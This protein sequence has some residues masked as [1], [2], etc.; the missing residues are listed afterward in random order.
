MVAVSGYIVTSNTVLVQYTVQTQAMFVLWHE[1]GSLVLSTGTNIH[2]TS[3]LWSWSHT[4]TVQR[5]NAQND[6]LLA[7]ETHIL[8]FGQ[9]N[10]KGL[11]YLDYD[12][13]GA[14]KASAK[15]IFCGVIKPFQRW[16]GQGSVRSRAGSWTPGDPAS[17]SPATAPTGN[18]GHIPL[19]RYV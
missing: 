18:C 4:L 2:A 5:K 12:F 8:F 16:P 10:R 9:T 14:D 11:G 1:A 7:R 15:E 6:Y 17:C 13:L 19:W 3:A